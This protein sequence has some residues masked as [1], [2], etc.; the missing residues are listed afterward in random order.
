MTTEA[1][2]GYVEAVLA[3]SSAHGVSEVVETELR[4]FAEL[5]GATPELREKAIDE[6]VPVGQRLALVEANLLRPAHTV[7]R[8]AI[9]MLITAGVLSDVATIS[10]EVTRRVAATRDEEV[11][12]VTVAVALDAGQTQALKQALETLTGRSLDVRVTID[13]RV[14]GGVQAR[15]GDTVID[16]S[17]VSRLNQLR[18]RVGA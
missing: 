3:L 5:L 2:N 14:L 7:T 13:E 15:I 10:E 11:A 4:S 9:A 6:R 1:T 17:L 8:T 16:G 18:T 12:E